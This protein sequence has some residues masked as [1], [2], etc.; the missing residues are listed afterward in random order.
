MWKLNSFNIQNAIEA[1]KQL[2]EG[3]ENDLDES[4]GLPAGGVA[5]DRST[6]PTAVAPSVLDI[7]EEEDEDGFF[8]DEIDELGDDEVDG[9]GDDEDALDFGDDEDA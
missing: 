2:A 6:K 4:V 5:G 9:F 7:D 1:A 8:D 3:L